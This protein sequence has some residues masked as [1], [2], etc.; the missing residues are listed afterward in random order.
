MVGDGDWR[1]GVAQQR[2]QP[3]LAFEIA[4]FDERFP[5]PFE[6]V[7]GEEMKLGLRILRAVT[8]LE[9]GLERGEIGIAP[10]VIGD[11]LAVDRAG[12]QAERSE[13]HTSELQSLMRISYAVF[14]L[15]KKKKHTNES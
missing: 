15:Q 7:E 12:R 1:R 8:A 10:R 3:L 9:H 6:Q 5:V 4:E 13:E 14:C 2:F 11:D